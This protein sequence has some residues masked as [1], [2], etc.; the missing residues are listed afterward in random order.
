MGSGAKFAA[1][2]VL[3]TVGL[4]PQQA[5]L[6]ANLTIM[7][8][9][10]AMPG[11]KEIATAFSR[12]TGHKVTVVL[13]DD[14]LEQRLNNGQVDLVTQNP[15]PMDELVKQGKIV[16][17]TVTPFGLQGG[18]AESE[19]DRLFAR[20]QRHEYREGDRRARTYRAIEGEDQLHRRQRPRHRLSQAWRIRDRH[21]ADQHH[22]GHPGNR[23][24]RAA[25]RLHEQAVPIERRVGDDVEGARGRARDDQV[26][27]LARGR[28]AAAQDAGRTVQTLERLLP[29]TDTCSA[30]LA[31]SASPTASANGLSG[32]STTEA[33]RTR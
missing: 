24:R 12:A 25:A 31:A 22:G 11:V 13:A 20:L 18:A 3:V 10:G 27:D 2:C 21:S 23:S 16:G 7:T 15:G 5:A 6:A 19:V 9:Q 28:A 4:M 32:G 1:A 8:N 14:S 30:L 26:H 29:Y 17:S 33:E